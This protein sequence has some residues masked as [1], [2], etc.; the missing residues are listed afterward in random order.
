MARRAPT[1]FQWSVFPA[2]FFG[3]MA[4]AIWLIGLGVAPP[5]AIAP[6]LYVAFLL[7]AILERIYPLHADWN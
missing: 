6:P 4:V 2:F 5:V 1:L 7:L 3:S